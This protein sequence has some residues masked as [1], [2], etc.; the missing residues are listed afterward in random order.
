[1]ASVTPSPT[2]SPSPTP[3]PTTAT[4]S[5]SIS[6]SGGSVAATL[7]GQTVTITVPPGGV[8]S[9]ATFK[10]TVYAAGTG[11]HKTSSQARKAQTL[12]PVTKTQ[13]L[14][15]GDSEIVDFVVDDGGVALLAPLQV[16]VTSAAAPAT[17]TTGYLEGFN[18]SSYDD[19]ATMSYAGGKYAQ[20]ASDANFPGATLA[21]NTEY[22]LYTHTGTQ[23]GDGTVTVNAPSPATTGTPVTVTAS[24]ATANG[25]PYLGRSFTFSLDN[26]S[27]GSIDPNTGVFTPSATGGSA[28]VTATDK[29]VTSRKGTASI[30]GTSSRPAAS[31]Q[32]A[33]YTGKMDEIDTNNVIGAVPA[34]SATPVPVT[35]SSTSRLSTTVS[36]STDANGNAVF[37]A[38]ESAAAAVRTTTTTTKT[39]IAYQANGS[40]TNVRAIGTFATDS[41]G[42]SY[43]TDYGPNNGLQTVLPETAV[44]SFS[45]DGQLNYTESDPGI[46][47]DPTTG[48]LSANILRHQNADGSYNELSTTRDFS[49]TT[50]QD[51]LHMNPDYSAFTTILSFGGEYKFD[52]P[53]P[54]TQVYGFYFINPDGSLTVNFTRTFP[55]WI[56]NQATPVVET[57]IIRPG[58]TLDSNCSVPAKYGTTATLVQQQ[59]SNVDAALGTLETRTVSSY[60]V[61]GAG[62]VCMIISD[63]TKFFYDYSGQEGFVLLARSNAGPTETI[64]VFETLSLQST[65]APGTSSAA[66][67]TS[68]IAPGLFLP[69]SLALS[70]VQHLARLATLKRSAAIRHFGGLKK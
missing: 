61:P 19:V 34:P 27:A 8:A 30:T 16:S 21:S 63:T 23:T 36:T 18:N 11:P 22:V 14:A 10:L 58:Q 17:G 26:P 39:T 37:T 69:R 1:M 60:D 49:G 54:T 52:A 70:R 33:V 3:T 43:Q 62:T 64:G 67:S 9:A 28:T 32:S 68:S 59:Q 56:P 40:T 55:R 24:E 20:P 51:T 44:T 7:V 53:G 66:R 48:A 31:G 65:N 35:T 4:S 25:F 38:V 41:N 46:N 15:T 2:P 57:D 6:A 50:Y 13:T 29:T 47:V 12:H 45:N 5:Q 42:A